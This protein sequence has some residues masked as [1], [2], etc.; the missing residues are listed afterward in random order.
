VA[1]Q[2]AAAG[3]SRRARARES[4]DLTRCDA[5]AV[6]RLGGQDGEKGRQPGVFGLPAAGRRSPRKRA[7]LQQRIH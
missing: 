5:A 6:A 2:T 4:R 3:R 7:E 1:V